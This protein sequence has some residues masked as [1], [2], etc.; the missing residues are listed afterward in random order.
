MAALVI[1]VSFACAPKEPEPATAP[2]PAPSGEPG[3]A[4][5]IEEERD[6]TNGNGENADRVPGAGVEYG[7]YNPGS[8]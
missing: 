4:R 3:V 8:R 1:L 6:S 2:T 5:L 7:K